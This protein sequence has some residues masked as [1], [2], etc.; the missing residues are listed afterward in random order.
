M[1]TFGFIGLGLIGGSIAKGIK[2]VHPNDHI[3][4]YDQDQ[5][6]LTAAFHEHTID[7]VLTKIDEHILD[8]DFVILCTPVAYNA[9]YLKAVRPFLKPG[10][11]L[12]DVG[13]TKTLIHNQ[14]IALDMEDCFIG[15]HPMAGSERSGYD[16]SNDHLVENAYYIITPTS[17][18]TPEQINRMI[19]FVSSLS[20]LPMV[21][22]YK[23]H[24]YVVAAISHLPHIIASTLINLVKDS[25][26][27]EHTMRQ[28]AAG[29]FKDIT[30]IASS[31]PVMWQQ[32]CLANSDN[33][34]CVLKNYITSLNEIVDYIEHKDSDALFRLFADSGKYRN[35]IADRSSGPIKKEYSLYCDIIDEAGAIATIATTLAIHQISIK[36]IGIIHNREF[37]Q[38]ALKIEFYTEQACMDAAKQ[39]TSCNYPVY[40]R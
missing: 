31:S 11:I 30:R 7:T 24:D 13:S 36:N 17:K 6:T 8:C 15:G 14:V 37:E 4:A 38:G 35:S 19:S 25:D 16:A 12:T 20:A 23:K 18:S 34:S 28:V 21:L 27:E 22:D 2:R 3:M 29:G 10:A 1:T 33:I 26:T 5:K 9:S 32:I 39:L 40:M